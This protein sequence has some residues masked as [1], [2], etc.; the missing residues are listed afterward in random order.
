[1]NAKTKPVLLIVFA[2]FA[3]IGASPAMAD[4]DHHGPSRVH[5]TPGIDNAQHRLHN[6]IVDGIR[7]GHIT[8]HEANI[9]FAKEKRIK[10]REYQFKSDGRVSPS[11]RRILKE[12]LAEFANDVERKMSNRRIS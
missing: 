8:R 1:M 3:L 2:A 10:R 9:L 12:E 4:H 7:S 5:E 11:E 6:R